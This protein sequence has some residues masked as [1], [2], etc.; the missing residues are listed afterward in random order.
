MK[1]V[2]K[3]VAKVFV[4]ATV[5][6]RNITVLFITK[7]LNAAAIRLKASNMAIALDAQVL[8][9]GVM[10]PT[11]LVVKGMVTA[12]QN[13][14]AQRVAAEL[15]VKNLVL[16]EKA[17]AKLITT[18]IRDNWMTPIKTGAAGDVS[19]IVGVGA[20]VKGQGPAPDKTRF[21]NTWPEPI[22]VNQNIPMKLALELIGNDVL[23]KG[24]P[25]GA[26]SIGCYRQIGGI[27]PLRN[28]HP[29]AVLI[30]PF[31]KMKFNDTYVVGQAGLTA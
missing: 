28:N 27:A 20:S 17:N 6:T 21:A 24:K 8:T 7:W 10:N 2:F 29:L 22:S 12:G 13:I 16:A 26:V 25:Y 3:K 5:L 19:K 11:T 23:S 30:N 4:M 14:A 1:K 31:S 9:F 18:T 15:L